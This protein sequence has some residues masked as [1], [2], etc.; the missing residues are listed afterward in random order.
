MGYTVSVE[1]IN[2]EKERIKVGFPRCETDIY[3]T[4][5]KVSSIG[6]RGLSC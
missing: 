1:F 4:A 5:Y 2:E 3:S 6:C